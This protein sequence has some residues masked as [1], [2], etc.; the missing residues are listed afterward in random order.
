[1][2]DEESCKSDLKQSFIDIAKDSVE[3]STLRS[4]LLNYTE[5]HFDRIFWDVRQIEELRP[6]SV[7]NIGGAPFI[8]EHLCNVLLPSSRCLSIDLDPSRF[9]TFVD[10]LGID[11]IAA[12]FEASAPPPRR[13]RVRRRRVQP[14]VRTLPN[15]SLRHAVL[16]EGIHVPFQFA[17]DHHPERSRGGQPDENPL[18]SPN[19][20][21]PHHGME[22]ALR[23]WPH[24]TRSRIQSPRTRRVL[25][26]RG[27]PRAPV[28]LSSPHE[29]TT[30]PEGIDS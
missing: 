1:M 14:D 9:S 22:K 19:G 20:A 16:I 15:Q 17:D 26:V 12:N 10:R 5:N 24:G 8:F 23:Y 30:K 6:K 21:F 18:L 4:W 25:P 28:R 29:P 13:S 27:T 2:A 3:D 7:L 11:V